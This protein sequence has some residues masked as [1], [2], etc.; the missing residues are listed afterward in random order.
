MNYLLQMALSISNVCCF[1]TVLY[2]HITNPY[3]DT[4]V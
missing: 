2:V 4:A 1:V 3:F